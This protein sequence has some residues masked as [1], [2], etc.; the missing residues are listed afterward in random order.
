MKPQTLYGAMPI[1][2]LALLCGCAVKAKPQAPAPQD[3]VRL[4]IAKIDA[5]LNGVANAA[6]AVTRDILQQYPENTPD[7]KA[8]LD[9]IY[10]I[11]QYNELARTL[12]VQLS[13]NDL[14]SPA[15][16]R[17][18]LGPIFQKMRAEIDSG[19]LGIKKPD[20]KKTATDV[21]NLVA[22][23]INGVAIILEAISASQ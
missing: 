14:T 13:T 2:C 7:R 19:L 11:V 23:S 12:L 8:V 6:Q 20:A 9:I 3:Q 21:T 10:K 17:D 4:I 15:G 1:L 16:I 22:I 18:A 5:G